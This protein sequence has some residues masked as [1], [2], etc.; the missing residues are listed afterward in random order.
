MPKEQLVYH[1][2][3]SYFTIKHRNFIMLRLRL[4]ALWGPIEVGTALKIYTSKKYLENWTKI[5]QI[6]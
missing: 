6:V 4:T 1:R 3:T 2:F 5:P